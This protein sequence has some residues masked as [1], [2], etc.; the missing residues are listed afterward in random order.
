[1]VIALLG[2]LTW[3]PDWSASSDKYSEPLIVTTERWA[4]I[5]TN[6]AFHKRNRWRYSIFVCFPPQDIMSLCSKYSHSLRYNHFYVHSWKQTRAILSLHS[7]L[8]IPMN[9]FLWNIELSWNN[10]GLDHIAL[11]FEWSSVE[12][13]VLYVHC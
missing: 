9:W 7:I 5:R 4:V 1:M 2:A 6:L 10:I 13:P 11:H 12:K 3:H 8:S